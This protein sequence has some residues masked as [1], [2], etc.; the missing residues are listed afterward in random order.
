MTLESLI[1]ALIVLPMAGFLITALIGRRLHKQAHWIPVLAVFAAWILAMGLSYSA[2]TGAEPFGEHGYGHT[3]FT[4]IPAYLSLPVEQ[5]GRG[6]DLMKTTTWLLV[7]GVGK[8]LGYTLFGFLADSIGR[9]RSYVGYL[10]V[11]ALLVPLYGM[12]TSPLWLLILGRVIQ[13]VGGGI[14]PLAFS[15]IRDELPN[16]RPDVRVGQLRLQDAA[17]QPI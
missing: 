16:D 11:A 10:T 5:G 7:M 12:A 17:R 14:F 8:W 9:R 2:L 4:W 15:I 1:P 6:L 3:L 13:G